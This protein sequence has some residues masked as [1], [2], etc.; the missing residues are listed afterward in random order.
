VN[1]YSFRTNDPDTRRIAISF[2]Y[3]FGKETFSRKRKYN[4]DA[5]DELKERAQ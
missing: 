2:S 1:A 4:D 5:A 3:N